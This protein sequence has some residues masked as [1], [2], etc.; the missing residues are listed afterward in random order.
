MT[1]IPEIKSRLQ[2][3]AMQY[4]IRRMFLFGSYAKGTQ[5]GNSD[6]DLL[7]EKGAP[8]SLLQLSGFLQ[9]ASEA[10][11][12]DVDVVTTTGIE[13]AFRDTIRGTEVLIYEE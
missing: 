7:I 3:I 9:D 2:P 13:E 1:D 5:T 4:G 8:P 6:V 11:G 10:L 12:M